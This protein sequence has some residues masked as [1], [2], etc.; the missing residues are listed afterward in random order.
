[1]AEITPSQCAA[2]RNALGMSQGDLAK[3]AR[4]AKSTV[5]AFEAGERQPRALMLSSIKAALVERGVEFL[6]VNGR[7]S[8]IWDEPTPAA[9]QGGDFPSPEPNQG[10]KDDGA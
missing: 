4:V 2:A 5:R 8:I 6:Y 7:P 3:A 1:M 9:S 10:E